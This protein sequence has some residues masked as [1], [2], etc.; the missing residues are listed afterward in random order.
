MAVFCSRNI[1]WHRRFYRW[2]VDQPIAALT[3]VF[4][5][6]KVLLLT[7]AFLSPGPGYDTSTTLLDTHAIDRD[8]HLDFSPTPK[9]RELAP[10][11]KLVR[12]D[13]IYFLSIARRGYVFEQEWAFSY[14][15]G[16]LIQALSGFCGGELLE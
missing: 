10:L 7:L 11:L 12:W 4:G 2:C 1:A 15:H 5:A 6:W 13:A 8:T 14:V 3:V 16:K 9:N